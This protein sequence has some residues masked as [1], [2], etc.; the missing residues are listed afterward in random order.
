M[1]EKSTDRIQIAKLKR[2]DTLTLDLSHDQ[3]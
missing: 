3:A 1:S 2:Y